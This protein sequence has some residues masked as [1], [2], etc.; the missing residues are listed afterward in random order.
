MAWE[1]TPTAMDRKMKFHFKNQQIHL[2]T[3]CKITHDLSVPK[4]PPH[5]NSSHYVP[6]GNGVEKQREDG[7]ED[8]QERAKHE[9]NHERVK[10]SING[11]GGS[12]R[13]SF[14]SA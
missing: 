10:F 6:I 4:M 3:L 1:V 5:R 12:R 8:I 13:R 11:S 2:L 9:V 14:Y 7:V